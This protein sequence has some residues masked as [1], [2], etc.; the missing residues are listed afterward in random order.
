MNADMAAERPKRKAWGASP[1]KASPDPRSAAKRRENRRDK[2]R[3][4]G[5]QASRRD[6]KKRA[7]HGSKTS[8]R[9]PPLCQP[10]T[11]MEASN[12]VLMDQYRSSSLFGSVRGYCA[13]QDGFD[14]G[15]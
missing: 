15:H 5:D 14:V 11:E 10:T 13:I 8:V 9:V 12:T 4:A 3:P 1:K 7:A 2:G 6:A